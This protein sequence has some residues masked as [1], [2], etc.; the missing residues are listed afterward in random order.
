MVSNKTT[1]GFGLPSHRRGE[2]EIMRDILE[3]CQ[4]GANKTKIVYNSNLNFCRLEKYLR[5][6]LSLGFVAV[7]EKSG[8]SIAY[9]TTKAGLNFVSGFSKTQEILEKVSEV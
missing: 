5:L 9:K 8:R 1:G 4:K 3:V 7:E 6:L 2:V